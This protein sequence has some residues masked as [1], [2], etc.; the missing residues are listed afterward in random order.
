MTLE[1]MNELLA[2]AGADILADLPYMT[3]AELFGLLLFL[4]RLAEG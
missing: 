3:E 4:A 2:G 1:R